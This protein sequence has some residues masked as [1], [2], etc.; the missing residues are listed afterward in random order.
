MLYALAM[1]SF[2][3][4]YNG[5]VDLGIMDTRDPACSNSTDKTS[6]FR[7]Y[8]F[9]CST[10]VVRGWRVLRLPNVRHGRLSALPGNKP[11]APVVPSF[12]T[13]FG[14][15]G[16]LSSLVSH[17]PRNV[18]TRT[19]PLQELRDSDWPVVRESDA[20]LSQ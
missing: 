11:T 6:A 14:N 18:L 9:Y 15:N 17:L 4:F 19:L 3:I 7:S 12:L 1:L 20:I 10:I 2:A 16:F 5:T 8:L 13:Y